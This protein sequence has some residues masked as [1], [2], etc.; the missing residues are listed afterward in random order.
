MAHIMLANNS[1]HYVQ[2]LF[3]S[4]QNINDTLLII[5]AVCRR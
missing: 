3:N 4:K 5:N 2:K 1:H